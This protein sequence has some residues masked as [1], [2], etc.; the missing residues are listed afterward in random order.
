MVQA[1]LKVSLVLC[2]RGVQLAAETVDDMVHVLLVVA[3]VRGVGRHHR[4]GAQLV[5]QGHVRH[6]EPGLRFRLLAADPP[7]RARVVAA[8]TS[9]GLCIPGVGPLRRSE[10]A[11]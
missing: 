8:A 9:A 7:Q 3:V 4:R 10:L 5:G 1:F 2:A 6:E 11:P